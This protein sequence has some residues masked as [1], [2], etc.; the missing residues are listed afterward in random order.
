V[1]ETLDGGGTARA[2]IRPANEAPGVVE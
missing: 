1:L 2:T